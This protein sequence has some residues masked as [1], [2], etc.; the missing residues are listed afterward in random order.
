MSEQTIFEKIIARDI[1]AD[2]VYEDESHIAILD[3]NP[4]EKGHTLV[5]PK[6]PY[7]TILD[8]SQ[9][10]YCALQALVHRIATHMHEQL[11]GGLNVHINNY[12]EA[13][14]EVPHVHIHLIPR[15]EDK[16]MYHSE[17]HTAGYADEEE[18]QS[19]VEKLKLR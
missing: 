4:F 11:G 14:Q 5:I 8:M 6:H 10:E 17:N 2:I 12:P 18:K 1:P 3:I 13:H 19:F 9:D 15:H 7:E 16:A